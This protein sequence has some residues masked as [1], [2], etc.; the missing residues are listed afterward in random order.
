MLSVPLQ[1]RECPTRF[2]KCP[3][4]RPGNSPREP[5]RKLSRDEVLPGVQSVGLSGWLPLRTQ[6]PPSPI[7]IQAAQVD[8]READDHEARHAR[9]GVAQHELDRRVGFEGARADGPANTSFHEWVAGI[10][11]TFDVRQNLY[12]A[13]QTYYDGSGA[14]RDMRIPPGSRSCYDFRS[15]LM[16]RNP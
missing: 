6:A 16:H 13:V 15:I 2:R 4:R 14:M 5:P 12:V 7:N 3:T 11:Y 1:F 8:P 9:Q 10:D